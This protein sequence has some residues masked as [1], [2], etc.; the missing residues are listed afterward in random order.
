MIKR[1]LEQIR[2]IV[3]RLGKD[4]NQDA[5]SEIQ[6]GVATHV[7]EQIQSDLTKIAQ[8]DPTFLDDSDGHVNYYSP[9]AEAQI[10]HKQE[11]LE[12]YLNNLTV[13]EAVLICIKERK[14]EAAELNTKK[15]LSPANKTR[16]LA[17]IRRAIDSLMH[18][19]EPSKL[20]ARSDVQ[21]KVKQ[22][23]EINTYRTEL[24]EVGIK[25]KR[26][27]EAEQGAKIAEQERVALEQTKTSLEG[28]I[29]KFD[30]EMPGI[31]KKVNKE[32]A[33]LQK[34]L[35]FHL[36][37]KEKIPRGMLDIKRALVLL[38][39]LSSIQIALEIKKKELSNLQKGNSTIEGIQ[40]EIAQLKQKESALTFSTSENVNKK[41][42]EMLKELQGLMSNSIKGY[43][44]LI[45]RG[46]DL[47]EYL[48]QTTA[49]YWE[50]L[51][52][53]RKTLSA[54]NE[55]TK[56]ASG[57][58]AQGTFL[59]ECIDNAYKLT[60]K[61]TAINQAL[62]AVKKVD[63]DLNIRKQQYD[64]AVENQQIRF[65]R[66]KAVTLTTSF[67]NTAT[68]PSFLLPYNPVNYVLDHPENT[69]YADARGNC[70]GETQMFLQRINGKNP[71][72][73]NICPETDLLNFQLD[74]TRKPSTEGAAV[75]LGTVLKSADQ[76]GLTWDSIKDL[77]TKEV[78]SKKHGDLCYFRLDGGSVK[79]HDTTVGHVIGFIKMKDPSPYK[80]V[81]YDYSYGA[82]GF[83]DD[84]QLS[85][86]F[87]EILEGEK[88]Y[89]YFSKC[90]FE[91]VGEVSN[92]CQKFVSKI[93]PLEPANSLKN[94]EPERTI[95]RNYW[96][97]ERLI[98]LLKYSKD[99]IQEDLMLA[100]EKVKLLQDDDKD[101]VYQAIFVNKEVKLEELFES[102]I[103]EDNLE[104][105]ERVLEKLPRL[106]EN[107]L[108]QYKE[109][110]AQPFVDKV[111]ALIDSDRRMPKMACKLFPM[112][113]EIVLDSF[114]QRQDFE[115]L[116]L[117]N[118]D[119]VKRLVQ[120]GEITAEHALKA[121]PNNNA[122][123]SA[124]SLEKRL[125][126]LEL[127][128]SASTEK[129][130]NTRIELLNKMNVFILTF[131]ICTLSDDID[132]LAQDVCL[133]LMSKINELSPDDPVKPDSFSTL[134]GAELINMMTSL[135]TQHLELIKH[136]AAA[137]EV[138][139]IKAVEE[140]AAHLEKSSLRER[141]GVTKGLKEV[142]QEG[143]EQLDTAKI[144]PYP[145]VVRA[146]F[147]SSSP[148][149]NKGV[150]TES[151]ELTAINRLIKE[152]LDTYNKEPEHKSN[153]FGKSQGISVKQNVLRVEY[154]EQI[155]KIR[156]SKTAP[157]DKF[158]QFIKRTEHYMNGL[159]SEKSVRFLTD[160]RVAIGL[161]KPERP[162]DFKN[163]WK[164]GST[165]VRESIV[166]K[167]E[168]II[169]E[170]NPPG[171]RN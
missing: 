93:K 7:L 122:L 83:A 31:S 81:L 49:F 43:Q 89:C 55:Y 23:N 159:V 50:N 26:D 102:S 138:A 78:H 46:G 2:R 166:T 116:S 15:D 85:I 17:E 151:I 143:M 152:V 59:V 40:K 119:L 39:E 141:A 91:K 99:S 110:L 82:M 139:R 117:A 103:K 140:A 97:K 165:T 114:R 20:L 123:K 19:K 25:L 76:A 36:K 105:F 121:F 54:L 157:K 163:A 4:L 169:T 131:P 79:G 164:E 92:E 64:V 148:V 3:S 62:N 149:V 90:S 48:H 35:S 109:D 34:Y 127:L 88:G 41:I 57:L 130:L 87:K 65:Y 113:K 147:F 21:K 28:K 9:Y 144:K 84:E 68:K 10:N 128:A 120:E 72:I 146:N 100:L 162:I 129:E 96:T 171:V 27:D 18:I 86:F 53:Y 156:D 132:V 8:K 33:L 126:S 136:K 38:Q 66:N 95:A 142:D 16:K 73:N 108:Y 167:N 94:A 168:L 13:V 67:F 101:E 125:K 37:L 74:Q 160:L 69:D 22:L 112:H 52:L 60:P 133:Q 104:L 6:L 29:K 61:E 77:L 47:N 124:V 135:K 44:E 12:K 5:D 115:A 71:S 154:M 30:D 170:L 98:L 42:K 134:K 58:T 63:T 80:Y 111:I 145:S 24:N 155:S 118:I 70:Y 150:G 11:L 107:F 161:K 75:K 56:H 137:E 32:N 158:E 1:R 14:Q 51:S 45:V 153:F 106:G